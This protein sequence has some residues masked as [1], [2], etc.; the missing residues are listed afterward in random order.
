MRTLT[1]TTPDYQIDDQNIDEREWDERDAGCNWIVN[2]A[3]LEL[4]QDAQA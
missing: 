1:I 2:L 3:E 4:P